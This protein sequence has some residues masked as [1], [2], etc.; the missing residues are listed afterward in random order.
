MLQITNFFKYMNSHYHLFVSLRKEHYKNTV[1]SPNFLVWTFC[2]KAQFPH[3]FRRFS[4][5]YAETVPFHKVSHQE[6][7]WN[8]RLFR[9]GSNFQIFST[10]SFKTLETIL[11]I[12][13]DRVSHREMWLLQWRKKLDCR[14]KLKSAIA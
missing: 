10:E 13:R 14:L 2:G 9:R 3:S 6:I 8:Y 7:L 5:N 1:I 4:Q 12:F 11:S